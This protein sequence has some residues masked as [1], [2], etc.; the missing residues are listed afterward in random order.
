MKDELINYFNQRSSSYDQG[1]FHPK[2]AHLLVQYSQ[3]QTGQKVLDLATG[4]GLVAIE[5]AQIIGKEGEVI[6]VD[7]AAGMLAQAQSKIENLG[8]QNIQ[9]IQAEA[10]T[11]DFPQQ[12]FDRILCCSALPYLTN[13]DQALK[14]WHFLLKKDGLICI[15]GF[16]TQAFMAGILMRKIFKKYGVIL[17]EFNQ[18]TSTSEQCYQL[19]A[20]A[21]FQNIEIKTLQL[22]SYMTLAEGEKM[23]EIMLKNPLSAPVDQLPLAIK[24]QAQAEY[25][26]AIKKLLTPQGIWNDTTTFFLLGRR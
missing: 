2:L 8:L 1:E 5:V 26:Q 23:W 14:H 17:P 16:S 12:S 20:R 6:G 22:G 15:S 13:I 9:L 7:I 25:N 19:L 10:E 11:I 24:D 3:I 18:V 21:G 4:T